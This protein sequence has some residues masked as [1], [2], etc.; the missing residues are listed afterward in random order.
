MSLRRLLFTLVLALA[1]SVA[2]VSAASAGGIRDWE[3]CPDSGGGEL[4]CPAGT[5]GVPYSIKFRAVEEPPC[6][7][8]EDTWHII[9]DA[10]PQGLTLA[11][12]GTLSGTPTQAGTYSFWVEM[13][14]PNNDHCNGT[15]DTTQER[16][17][18]PIKP[19]VPPKPKLTIGPEQSGVPIGTVGTLFS[20]PMTASVADPKTWSISAGA[21]PPGLN[22]GASDGLISGTPTVAGAYAFTVHAQ[23]DATSTATQSFTLNVRD[24]LTIAG[25]ID[26]ALE[27]G[28][29]YLTAL[30]GNGGL[31][32]YKWALTAGAM[33]PGLTFFP[34]GAITGRPTTAGE[35]E[36]TVT[37][38]DSEGRTLTY[39]GSLTVAA[40]LAV[41]TTRLTGRAGRVFR[42][43]VVTLGGI[44]P[45]SMRLKKGPL[46]GGVRFDRATA[47]F[48][49]TPKKAGTW[50]V[51]VEVVDSL[52]VKSTATITITVGSQLK[53][54]KSG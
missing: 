3:P 9:N 35:F 53:L 32:T 15:T 1:A 50:S 37:L 12:D 45:T 47:S 27:V 30:Q 13:R 24:A 28:V 5:V 10:P 39:D 38:T 6:S 7:P 36:F 51:I 44:D 49:G 11:S 8:G 34:G 21:L 19:G 25:P 42:K 22:L 40:R 29:R 26:P 17:T 46:P 48:V 43:K 4:L 31:R 54:R 20:L 2:V 41:A 18:V 14:L 33:P 23:I 16:F 52:R